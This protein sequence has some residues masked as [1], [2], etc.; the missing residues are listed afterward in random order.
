V[1]DRMALIT[2]WLDS[3]LGEDTNPH[4]VRAQHPEV[5]LWWEF[6]GLPREAPES[7]QD[8][9]PS[10]HEKFSRNPFPLFC[11][12]PRPQSPVRDREHA[13]ATREVHIREPRNARI[14][15]ALDGGWDQR[16][17]RDSKGSPGQQMKSKVAQGWS[18]RVPLAQHGHG[19]PLDSS[20]RP[21]SPSGAR[22]VNDRARYAQVADPRTQIQHHA[23]HEDDDDDDEDWV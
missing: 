3:W 20:L 16:E 18:T 15:Q 5:K 2:R 19:R 22:E 9:G 1:F 21:A 17:G 12:D 10:V 6:L 4:V 8:T 7:P 13:E 14:M 11:H 23:D